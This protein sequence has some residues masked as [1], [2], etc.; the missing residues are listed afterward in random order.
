MGF[1]SLDPTL[2]L[3]V[4]FERLELQTLTASTPRDSRVEG[5]LD[6]GLPINQGPVAIESDDLSIVQGIIDPFFGG[7]SSPVIVSA[8]YDTSS[9]CHG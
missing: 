5:V 6:S 3:F 2:F 7:F 9:D 1:L 8:S 4:K